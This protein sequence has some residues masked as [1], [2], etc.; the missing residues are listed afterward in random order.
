MNKIINFNEKLK[1][2]QE[3]EEIN[4]SKSFFETFIKPYLT[5]SDKRALLKAIENND[6]KTM[7]AI[8]EP[9]L[10]KQLIR[11]FN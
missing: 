7:E 5:E 10:M 1:A 9:I 4:K 8:T 3:Q 6:K 2:R 11:E